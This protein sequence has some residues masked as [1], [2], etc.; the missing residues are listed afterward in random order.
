MENYVYYSIKAMEAND[1]MTHKAIIYKLIIYLVLIVVAVSLS[2]WLS[3]E[4]AVPFA[5][6]GSIGL[7]CSVCLA[8]IV[9]GEIITRRR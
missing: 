7:I 1:S 8:S 5:R 3:N 4:I 6:W 9:I 2:I